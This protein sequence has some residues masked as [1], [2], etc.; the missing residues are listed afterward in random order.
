VPEET[1]FALEQNF[2][3]RKIQELL[4]GLYFAVLAVVD[5]EHWIAEN[6]MLVS[7]VLLSYSKVDL[8]W[9]VDGHKS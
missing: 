7:S 8:S 6:E 4:A 9:K 5:M 1:G 3:E 2:G